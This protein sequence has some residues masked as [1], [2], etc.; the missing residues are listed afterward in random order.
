[1]QN[2]ANDAADSFRVKLNILQN[3]TSQVQFADSTTPGDKSNPTLKSRDQLRVAVASE[4]ERHQFCI[5][6]LKDNESINAQWDK[7]IDNVTNGYNDRQEKLSGW[8][9]NLHMLKKAKTAQA[10]YPQLSND[11]HSG[12][13]Q[14]NESVMTEMHGLK[15][16]V[17]RFQAE[18][19]SIGE[20]SRANL[21]EKE[22]SARDNSYDEQVLK[23]EKATQRIGVLI[24]QTQQTQ[25]L[26]TSVNDLCGTDVTDNNFKAKSAALSRLSKE[27]LTTNTKA[28]SEVRATWA[29]KK[30]GCLAPLAYIGYAV[31]DIGS[32]LSKACSYFKT[33]KPAAEINSLAKTARNT[34]KQASFLRSAV[35]FFNKASKQAGEK[36]S[37]AVGGPAKIAAG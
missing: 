9:N 21:S 5:A 2:R 6:Y 7:R 17:H 4:I 37:A 26:L 13:S 36:Q 30:M 10:Q 32:C 8:Q 12:V 33:Q 11:F 29:E 18:V 1:M 14:L 19:K 35:T 23:I 31:A 3:V 16:S 22:S 24:T 28:V 15:S 20:L 25:L 34:A 27:I